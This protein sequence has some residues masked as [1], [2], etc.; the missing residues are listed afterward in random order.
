MYA[1]TDSVYI[2]AEKRAELNEMGFVDLIAPMKT[3][4]WKLAIEGD[5]H[6]IELASQGEFEGTLLNEF[7]VDERDGYLRVVTEA[8]R[9]SGQGQGVTVLEEAG[10]QLV[11][12]GSVTGIAANETQYS[13]RIIDDR[14]FFVTFVENIPVG[15]PLFVVD[16]SDPTNPT[17]MGELHIPGFSDYLEP[18]DETHLLAIGRNADGSG[19]MGELQVSI[20]DISDSTNP[21][22]TQRYNF[23]GGSTT[24]SPATGNS[25]IRGDGDHH[26]VSYYADEQILAL[27]VYTGASANGW[28]WSGADETP[29]FEMGQ[30][31]LQV[32]KVDVDSGFTPTGLIEH[33]TLINR[34]IRIGDRL[35]A[36]SDGTVSAHNLWDPGTTLSS[37]DLGAST[38]LAPAELKMY[39]PPADESANLIWSVEAALPESAPA[40]VYD[41]S[42][43]VEAADE[44]S[45]VPLPSAVWTPRSLVS[46][47][48]AQPALA[49]AFSQ[50]AP[51]RHV[52]NELVISLAS[53]TAIERTTFDF[54]VGDKEHE[55]DVDGGSHTDN[56]V[57]VFSHDGVQ[58]R[59][60]NSL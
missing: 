43:S 8:P 48:H 32:F 60:F 2:F 16:V 18:I 35:L 50:H 23:G 49:V 3:S 51:S 31:G 17:I 28:R 30:G 1:T 29:L 34:S 12:V 54:F 24:L 5:T 52:D 26:A 14:V 40:A 55:A 4:V 41:R 47:R 21:Q 20:F 10:G 6:S 42:F 9:W 25:F 15:D 27:P 7:A 45:V 36:I 58:V 39:V 56:H 57:D 13:V 37:V 22:L 19:N 33:D 59:A 44:T 53:E 11:V 38:D 46:I